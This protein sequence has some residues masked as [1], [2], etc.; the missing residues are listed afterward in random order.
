[1]SE[2]QSRLMALVAFDHWSWLFFI[3]WF[4]AATGLTFLGSSVGG[5]V[6]YWGIVIV[7]VNNVMRLFL[8]AGYFKAE[9]KSTYFRL[10]FLLI[11][12]LAASILFQLWIRKQL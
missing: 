1:M 5:A 3:V 7:L 8:L 12:A 4:A 11:F 9:R 6:T 2:M 10:T